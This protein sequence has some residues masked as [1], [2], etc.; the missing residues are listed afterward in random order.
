MN[1]LSQDSPGQNNHNLNRKASDSSFA[2]LPVVIATSG[3][4][5]QIPPRPKK[6]PKL[7][8]QDNQYISNDKQSKQSKNSM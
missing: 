5:Q 6:R 8:Q 4:S 2:R 7:N 1:G 3:P